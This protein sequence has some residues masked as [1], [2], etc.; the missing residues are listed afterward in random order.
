MNYNLD[1]RGGLNK[2]NIVNKKHIFY[3]CN[4]N[5]SLYLKDFKTGLFQCTWTLCLNSSKTKKV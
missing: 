4:K 1:I 5:V 2:F 3:L